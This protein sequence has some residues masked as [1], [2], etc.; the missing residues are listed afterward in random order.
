MQQLGRYATPCQSSRRS[1]DDPKCPLNSV[2]RQKKP[3]AKESRYVGKSS[4]S[5]PGTRAQQK[6]R[7]PRNKTRATKKK[8]ETKETVAV[9][10]TSDS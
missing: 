6:K 9:A 2:V 10:K 8:Y 1:P 3:N 4:A 5:V 7:H